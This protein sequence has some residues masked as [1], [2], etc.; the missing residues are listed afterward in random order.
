MVLG[1]AVKQTH[2][3]FVGLDI[4]SL[5]RTGPTESNELAQEVCS[6]AR[7]EEVQICECWIARWVKLPKTAP[8][9]GMPTAAQ[10]PQGRHG[11][12]NGKTRRRIVVLVDLADGHAGKPL[13]NSFQ[14]ALEPLA[15]LHATTA[16]QERLRRKLRDGGTRETGE[17]GGHTW[18]EEL[19]T[20]PDDLGLRG[21]TL[22]SV[23][24]RNFGRQS[25]GRRVRCG[26]RRG[27]APSPTACERRHPRPACRLACPTNPGAPG[28]RRGRRR[29]LERSRLAALEDAKFSKR[30]HRLLRFCPLRVRPRHVCGEKPHAQEQLSLGLRNPALVVV[31]VQSGL[32]GLPSGA[33]SSGAA[34]VVPSKA[35]SG[36]SHVT[37]PQLGLFP[38]AIPSTPLR[39]PGLTAN[40]PCWDLASVP[41]QCPAP[42]QADLIGGAV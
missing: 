7:A 37:E 35:L 13:E 30:K 21:A 15:A 32:F 39:T 11:R 40:T 14:L 34:A 5:T 4:G 42:A 8:K 24:G 27:P 26:S 1:E 18:P 2:K 41:S 10:R 29:S 3:P 33:F 6:A 12:A 17:A 23:A 16:R 28:R 20:H 19:T 31:V 25:A 38:S 9:P 22:E 36:F